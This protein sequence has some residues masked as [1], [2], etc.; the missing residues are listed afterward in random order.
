MRV[1]SPRQLQK[2]YVLSESETDFCVL[3]VYKKV[4]ASA[5]GCC[6]IGLTSVV[7]ICLIESVKVA[8]ARASGGRDF[9]VVTRAVTSNATATTGSDTGSV[10]SD[11]TTTDGPTKTMTLRAVDAEVSNCL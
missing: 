9:E 1:P 11:I 5:W 8:N 7:P 10:N 3:K 4:V 6:H 2:Y